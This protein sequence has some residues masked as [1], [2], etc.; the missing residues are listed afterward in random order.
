M[1]RS[2]ARSRSHSRSRSRP[3]SIW[4]RARRRGRAGPLPCPRRRARAIRPALAVRTPAR[5]YV[6]GVA[7]RSR[8][9]GR[10][11]DRICHHSHDDAVEALGASDRPNSPLTL[12]PVHGE[13]A[14]VP[15]HALRRSDV[16]GPRAGRQDHLAAPR[17]APSSVCSPGSTRS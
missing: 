17:P 11:V 5:F 13:I 16:G 6:M 2:V 1:A 14:G 9:P 4:R 3:G 10:A 8:A 7:A 15:A 12:W